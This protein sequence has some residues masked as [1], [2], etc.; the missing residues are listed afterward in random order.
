MAVKFELTS[1]D[2]L[3]HGLSNEKVVI[4]KI[5][6]FIEEN[7]EVL[8]S[9]M[10]RNY[11]TDNISTIPSCQCGELKGNYYLNTVCSRCNSRVS[12]SVEDNISFLLWSKQVEGVEKYI[13]P[14]LLSVLL[15]RYKITR[16]PTAIVEYLILPPNKLTKRQPKQNLHRLE[17]LDMLLASLGIPKGYNSFVANFYTIIPILEAEFVKG[18][19]EESEEFVQ[20]LIDN[21]ANIF[22][23]YLP[24]PNNIMFVMDSNPLGRFIDREVINPINT[25][26]RMTGIDLQTR[27]NNI[28]QQRVAKS[29]VELSKFYHNYMKSKIFPKPGLIRQH[30]SSTRSHF[31]ARG[32]ITSI[33]GPHQYDEIHLP[34][35][36]SVTLFRPHVLSGLY[37]RGYGY[38]QAIAFMMEHNR[39]YHP[40]MDEIFND[41]IKASGSGVR[42]MFN[43]NPG[44]HRGSIQTVR[45][46]KVKTDRDDNTISMSYLI[47]KSFNAD[48]DGD[49]LNL[50]LVLSDKVQR[51]L[52]NF[53]P[54]HNLLSL[55]GIN[56]FNDNIGYPKTITSSLASWYNS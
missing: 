6:I 56:E 49:A 36:M 45:V 13:S 47:A 16:P 48:F 1:F 44:L 30:V 52:D 7:K 32:V 43:R 3:Y 41:I 29:L 20:W 23:E 34:W 24:Y 14:Y 37:K 53:E 28:K 51:N 38:N 2:K 50:A 31:T 17:K 46:T 27:S 35:S 33:P 5:D 40:L 42:V 8:D 22:S 9:Y 15:D 11:D 25:I 19:K 39:T 55:S 10:M 18:P 12:A 21:Q 54:H 26:R 4:N